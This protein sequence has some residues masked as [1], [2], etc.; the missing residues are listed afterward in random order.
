MTAQTQTQRSASVK[1][2]CECKHVIF[3]LA[4]LQIYIVVLYLRRD[5][6]LCR[7]EEKRREIIL[8]DQHLRWALSSPVR[9]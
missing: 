1:S 8:K 4:L 7:E 5:I 2:F 9:V 6:L 3:L